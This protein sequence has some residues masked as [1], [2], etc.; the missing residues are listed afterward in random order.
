MMKQS[1]AIF[2]CCGGYVIELILSASVEERGHLYDFLVLTFHL[3]RFMKRLTP[4]M[5]ELR[6]RLIK[7]L[8]ELH[9]FV[10]MPIVIR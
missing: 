4:C 7:K 5:D 6:I 8:L 3:T 9:L 1:G 2:S 10:Q